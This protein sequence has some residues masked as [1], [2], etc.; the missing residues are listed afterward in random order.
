MSH[1]AIR[2]KV[3][4]VT[5]KSL[6]KAIDDLIKELDEVLMIYRLETYRKIVDSLEVYDIIMRQELPAGGGFIDMDVLGVILFEFKSSKRE[7]EDAVGQ[8]EEY[9]RFTKA[10]YAVI[11]DSRDWRFYRIYDRKLTMDCETDLGKAREKLYSIFVS[12]LSSGVGLAPSQITIVKLFEEISRYE[13]DLLRVLRKYKDKDPVKPLYGVHKSIISTLYGKE[14]EEFYE[15]LYVKHTLMQMIVCSCLTSALSISSTPSEA[16]S[17]SKIEIEVALPYLNWW[18]V[19]REIMDEDDR[20]KI[21]EISGEIF[22]RSNLISWDSG[23]VE[24][25]FRELY[26]L[27]IDPETRRKIGEYYTPLWLVDLIMERIKEHT[28]LK[29]KIVLDP[30]CGSGTFLVRAFH[31]KV[32]SGEDP[33]DAIKEVIGFDVNPLAVSIARAELMLA[34]RMYEKDITTPLIFH[35]DTLAVMC[36]MGSELRGISE[37]RDIDSL[38][39]GIGAEISWGTVKIDDLTDLLKIELIFRE[40]LERIYH[41]EYIKVPERDLGN[42][43]RIIVENIERNKQRWY[44]VLKGIVDKYGNGIW[45]VAITSSI[46]P[47]VIARAKADIVMTN[48]PWLNLSKMKGEYGEK[49]RK[50]AM[51]KIKNLGISG[52]SAANIVQGSDLASIALMGGIKWSKEIVAYVMPRDSS[53]SARQKQ[54]GI[55]LTYA[56][57]RSTRMSSCEIIDVD[58]D[59]FKHGQYPAIIILRK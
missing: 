55:L 4:E 6:M 34:Y 26:E 59:A 39:S 56:I 48:P 45:S 7:F 21:D 12:E 25:V 10:K 50:I 43:G 57:L 15:R 33:K 14:P 40:I 32:S 47:R 23:N 41:G 28:S 53:F 1:E 42:L 8:V 31:D 18:Y 52:K 2:L 16:C 3:C 24:D 54:S 49:I 38:I 46:A 30:F 17:G 9:L 13:D 19:A 37:F 35:S 58:Y 44:K 5:R 20:K 51:S 36:E 29:G 27:L 11:T 22:V